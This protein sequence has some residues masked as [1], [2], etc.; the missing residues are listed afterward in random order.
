MDATVIVNRIHPAV[1]V[2]RKLEEDPE[3]A[4]RDTVHVLGDLLLDHAFERIRGPA[5][6]QESLPP[7]NVGAAAPVLPAPPAVDPAALQAK[8]SALEIDKLDAR[9][10]AV[11]AE[12]EAAVLRGRINQ[13]EAANRGLAD[14]VA[15]LSRELDTL[16]AMRPQRDGEPRETKAD[17]VKAAAMDAAIDYE[18]TPPP[19]TPALA[20]AAA[21]TIPGGLIDAAGIAK[22]LGC[23]KSMVRLYAKK[24]DFPRVAKILGQHRVVYWSRAEIEAWIAARRERQKVPAPEPDLLDAREVCRAIGCTLATFYNRVSRHVFPSHT[25]TRDTR[26]LWRRADVE[27]WQRAQPPASDARES[28]P[29][30]AKSC[31]TCAALVTVGRRSICRSPSLSA[32]HRNQ[33]RQPADS[34]DC[35]QT[36]GQPPYRSSRP[37]DQGE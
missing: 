23:S 30:E 31:A 5:T 20:T 2:F 1:E 36:K 29:Q 14:T 17:R 34:C 37:E 26:H 13:L 4:I 7:M 8:I 18:D 6:R 35:H 3:G 19:Q 28:A 10:D 24:P 25:Q 21:G 11:N 22:L 27:A 16:R 9:A 33:S 32:P 12:N 15:R